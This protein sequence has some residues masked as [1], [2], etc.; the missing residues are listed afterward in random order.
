M[1]ASN[2]FA[3]L[4]CIVFILSGLS[5]PVL[6]VDWK[7]LPGHLPPKAA[8][9][10][11]EGGLPVTNQLQLTI[12]LPLRDEA[13]L[14]QFLTEV[15]DPHNADFRKFLTPEEVTARFGPTVTDY[16]RVKDFA[17]TNGLSITAES[18]NRLILEVS[19]PVAQINR[20]FHIT[21]QTYRHPSE[22]R[23]F[24]APDREPTVEAT[25]PITNVEGLS[26]FSRPQPRLHPENLTAKSSAKDGSGS[27][28]YYL[29]DD[30]RAAYA[31]GTTLTGAGQSVGLLEFDGFYSNDI[32]TYAAAAGG[33]RT[34]IVIQT[35]LLNGFN[36]TPGGGNA[37]V[38]LDIEMAMAMAPGL[39]RIVV[40][41]GTSGSSI[42]NAMATNSSVKNLSSSWGWTGGPETSYDSKFKIMAAQ[43][44]SFF[45]A[46]GDSDAFTVGASSVNGVDNPNA[47]NAPS[48]CPYITQV[49]G[50]TLSTTGP[51]GAWT[52]E[53]VWNIDN[54]VGSGGGV[55]SYYT[56]P[57][58]QTNTSMTAN[59][60]ST[61]YR[62]IP[63][64]A[65]A[66]YDIWVDYG[67]G[68]SGGFQ[69]TSCA[70]PL[71]A[72]FAA[73]VN[74]QSALSGFGPVGFM[75]PA[76]YA[77]GNNP[78]MY[79]N[80][81]NDITSGNNEWS[82]SSSEYSAVT[83]YDLCTGWGTPAGTNLINA[84][85]YFSNLILVLPTN[86][87]SATGFGDGLFSP[88]SQTFQLT[89]SSAYSVNWKISHVPNWLAI[90]PSNGTLAGFARTTLVFNFNAAT[91]NLAFGTY[92]TNLYLTNITIVASVTNIASEMFPATLQII[93]AMQIN[94]ATANV[95]NGSY[96]GPFVQN[97]STYTVNNLSPYNFNWSL[98]NTS[99]WLTV[100][101][102]SGTAPANGAS[103][104]I[105]LSFAPAAYKLPA[106]NYSTAL[107]FTNLTS[108]TSQVV[109]STLS[110]GQNIVGNGGFETGNFN[111][112]TLA[113]SNSN[114][115]TGSSQFVH[116]GS[117]GAAL[118]QK[119]SLA[120]LSQTLLTSPG[121][122][123]LLSFWLENPA[124][125]PTQQ[126]AVNWNGNTISNLVNPP[127]FGWTD[128]NYFVTATGTNTVLQFAVESD[129]S[130]FGLDDVAV[131]PVP[132][133]TFSSMTSSA[134]NWQFTW[135]AATDLV[136]Q[137]QYSTNLLQTNWLNLGNAV[138][139]TTN[140]LT[141]TDTNALILSPQR[142]YRL[143]VLP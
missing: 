55:S 60:G 105:A 143:D 58:W 133:I 48:S 30:F 25:L 140:I 104:G 51:D 114:L 88:A 101:P 38:S 141:V 110:I 83:G 138:T 27:Y 75:N 50:T 129:Q 7:T 84:L 49:G 121:Q 92:T 3:R 103:A 72:G 109:T 98:S 2:V 10:T 82:D 94:P 99:A 4:V 56:I 96:G 12:S 15:Y 74:Q 16:A 57:F 26:D 45:N 24:F 68:S 73:L 33:G 5:G 118:G 61:T 70:A 13:G 11:E 6:A 67:N 115:V 14:D 54:G 39:T 66:A 137:V 119:G 97:F 76:I 63:D 122:E 35:V 93:N 87:F 79:A 36:G 136:Y 131:T 18:G 41:E 85:V 53:S 9:L 64:V 46:S 22:K 142:F 132:A 69:G 139:A 40:Y 59:G 127:V 29:G 37:E 8:A 106:N 123:Y 125:L 20:A 1:K 89:N 17:R 116:T 81:F 134:N 19:G 135:L 102:A 47:T 71:W 23:N 32:A 100:S 128:F 91:T 126:F 130:F 112:W 34:N 42:I 108:H 65:I 44:Q 77:I 31:P 28:G 43:G 124:D 117:Y 113:G 80:C 86:N 90:A 95:A 21:L 52:G 107:Q 78:A 111:S 62:N 120:T